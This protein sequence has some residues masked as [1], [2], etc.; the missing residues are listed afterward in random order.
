MSRVA[1]EEVTQCPF[2]E[3]VRQPEPGAVVAEIAGYLSHPLHH[4]AV[5]NE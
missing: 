4:L 3:F 1:N 2:E 5:T